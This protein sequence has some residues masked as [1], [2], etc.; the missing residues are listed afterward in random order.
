MNY[1]KEHIPMLCLYH[2]D[3]EDDTGKKESQK[4]DT[5]QWIGLPELC[6]NRK[7]ISAYSN[8]Q[9]APSMRIL[10]RPIGWMSQT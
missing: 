5:K 7:D 1:K 4:L 3:Y 2:I 6:L 8:N 9:L 10:L